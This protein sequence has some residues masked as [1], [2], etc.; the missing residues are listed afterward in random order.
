MKKK[1]N[2]YL[3]FIEN[4][5]KGNFVLP[6]CKK[7]KKNTWPPA[8]ICRLCLGVLSIENSNNKIG[9]IL[10]IFVPNIL[11]Y[12]NKNILMILVEINQ[13]ILLGS[14]SFDQDT[15]E[16]FNL[17]HKLVRIKKCGFIDKKIFYEFELCKEV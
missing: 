8:D 11:K 5:R 16:R 14:V 17:K 13:L 3:T 12:N 4:I 15:I 9:Q 10:E 7:C 2:N 6:Y 1:K